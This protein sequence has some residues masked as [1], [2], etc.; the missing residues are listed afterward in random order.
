MNDGEMIACGG[1]G[2]G[3]GLGLLLIS[4]LIWRAAVVSRIGIRECFRPDYQTIFFE[5]CVPRNGIVGSCA[6]EMGSFETSPGVSLAK[7]SWDLF[8]QG[9]LGTLRPC[10]G[11][12]KYPAPCRKYFRQVFCSECL[13]ATEQKR[14]NIECR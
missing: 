11:L 9:P 2:G 12:M 3:G 10:D 5:I 6:Q 13:R 4:Q 7:F 1:G 8:S 14:K